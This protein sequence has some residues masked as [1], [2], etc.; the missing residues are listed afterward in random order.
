MRRFVQ[1]DGELIE[2]TDEMR[3]QLVP[4]VVP[5]ID[6]YKSMV[7]GE[8]ITSRSK[9]R[10]HLTRHGFEEI[11]KDPALFRPK[12]LPDV[13]PQKRKELI[14][15][16]IASLTDRQFREMHKRAIDNWKWNSRER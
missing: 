2:V 10:E 7:N 4:A 5:D 12:Q 14:R 6:P 3:T 8:M 9:H 1:I 11:G 16:Q 15:S 13:S